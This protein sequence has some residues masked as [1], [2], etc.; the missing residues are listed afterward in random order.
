[1]PFSN[2]E[3]HVQQYR[4]GYISARWSQLNGLTK[5]WTDKAVSFLTLTNR[6]SQPLAR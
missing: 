5:D 1:M 6:W 4:F 2:E 3:S